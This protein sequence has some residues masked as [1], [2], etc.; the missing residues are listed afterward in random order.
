MK[1]EWAASPNFTRGRNGR[2]PLAIIN[3][4]TAGRYPGCLNWMQNPQAKASAHYLV[5]R[6]GKIIQMVADVDTSWH[7]GVVNKPTWKLYDGSNPN[8]YT[9]GIEHEGYGIFGGD[10][11]LTVRQ[12]EA[13]LWLQRQLIEKWDMKINEDTITGHYQ[14]DSVNRPNCPGKNFP[15]QQLLRDLRRGVMD[16]MLNKWMVEEGRA[17]VDELARRGLINNPEQH[18]SEKELAS[19]VP[20]YLLWIMISRL[21]ERK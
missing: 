6:T 5:T 17:A 13:T 1:I 9:I 4:I 11:N 7:A 21:L 14:I 8:R 3:H 20:R 12:Y 2:K 16:R 10:G 18:K 19:G 15:W